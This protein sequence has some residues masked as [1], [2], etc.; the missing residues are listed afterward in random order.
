MAK[1]EKGNIIKGTITGIESYGVFV[2]FGEFYTGLI[3]ISEIS[4]GYVNDIHDF[5]NIGDSI[6]VEILSVNNETLQLTLSIKNIK[7]K[8]NG[9]RKHKKIKE[10]G[11]GFG[12]LNEMLPIWM[13]EK[14]KE[15]SLNIY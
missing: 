13:E 11:S 4:N 15:K 5:V 14:I 9:R 6:Y 10:T 8:I 1:Y 12:I 3:H 2:S 7:Y